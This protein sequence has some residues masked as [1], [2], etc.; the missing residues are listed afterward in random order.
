MK[1]NDEYLA[2]SHQDFDD[3]M[4]KKYPE[5]FRQRGLDMKETCMCWGFDI[6][7]GWYSTLDKLCEDLTIIQKHSGVGVEFTQIKEK[8]GSGRFYH[9]FIV[10][11]N[12]I[13]KVIYKWLDTS[14]LINILNWLEKWTKRD[15]KFNEWSQIIDI[16]ISEAESKCDNVCAECG[17]NI[18]KKVVIGR[19]VHDEC[20]NCY[21]KQHPQNAHLFKETEEDPDDL[22]E[23]L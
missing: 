19:W 1:T 21:L 14:K 12:F 4:C 8:Y 13:S 23:E 20:K 3:Y 18:Y 9:S 10:K 11:Q 7:K 5:F 17:G 15:K 2:M 16:L 22:S 6:G